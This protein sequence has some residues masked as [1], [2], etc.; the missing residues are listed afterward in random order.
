[1]AEYERIDGLASW[2][3]WAVLLAREPVDVCGYE[4]TVR[5]LA[6]AIYVKTFVFAL[7]PLLRAAAALA[8]VLGA[9]LAWAE[10]CLLLQWLV[11]IGAFP[12][13]NRNGERDEDED[14][15]DPL[16]ALLLGRAFLSAA[17]AAQ[18][19]LL[20]LVPVLWMRFCISWSLARMHR[21]VLALRRDHKGN[22]SSALLL[23]A[24]NNI[25]LTLALCFNFDC[26]LQVCTPLRSHSSIPNGPCASPTQP[27]YTC[28]RTPLSTRFQNT[29]TACT[30]EAQREGDDTLARGPFDREKQ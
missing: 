11:R 1:V 21:G 30:H 3:E 16:R 7:Q 5:G 29:H 15:G 12:W 14:G 10:L 26:L 9:M 18:A 19:P 24:T 17:E 20:L 13:W 4:T 28:D 25:R 23:D 8:F 2:W 27:I 22:D 6:T